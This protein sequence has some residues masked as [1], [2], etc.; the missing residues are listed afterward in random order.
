MLFIVQLFFFVGCK[1]KI[2]PIAYSGQLL[3]SKKY[4]FPI[5]N[6]K[7]EIY[8]TG[9]APAIGLNSGSTSSSAVGVTDANGNFEIS[10][11]PGTSRF[12]FLS[13]ANTKPMVLQSALGDTTFPHFSRKNF[14]GLNFNSPQPVHIGKIIDSVIVEVFLISDLNST[15]TIGLRANTINGNLEKEYT[16]LS[17]NAGTSITVDTLTNLLFT[18]FESFENKFTNTV[19]VGRKWTT[20][21]GY[22]TISYEGIPSPSLL[23][24]IDETKVTMNFSFRK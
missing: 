24:D 7:I 5:A 12:I 9:S 19:N 16:G 2:E 13:G 20:A 18:E 11:T 21:F 4:P 10:F 1:K 8:Q 14:P 23:S 6:K 15:D 3:L 22:S 17:G